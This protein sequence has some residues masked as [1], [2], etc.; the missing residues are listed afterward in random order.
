MMA[1]LC[2]F[3]IINRAVAGFDYALKNDYIPVVDMKNYPNMYLYDNEVGYINSWEYYCE[4]P[5]G[6]SLEDALSSRKY[7]LGRT[8]NL[9]KE[10][11]ESDF[12]NILSAEDLLKDN[13]YE[14]LLYW[15]R[16]YKKF[17]R[18][19]PEVTKRLESMTARYKDKR[20]LGILVRGTDYAYDKPKNHSIPP[21]AE[22]AI[23]K[24]QEV[25]TEKKFDALY[26]ATEDKK[27]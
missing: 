13:N 17:L 3:S 4:Q 23:V 1:D 2:F 24:A 9:H 22:Q 18:F 15:R 26:L 6:M 7:I 11:P 19:K 27:K 12:R 25:M 16:L 10:N 5:C 20:I 8:S 14:R 21:T